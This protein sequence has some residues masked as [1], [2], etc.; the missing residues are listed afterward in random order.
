M[1]GSSVQ[2]NLVN[3]HL[4]EHNC[5]GDHHVFVANGTLDLAYDWWE[6]TRFSVDAKIVNGDV[7]AFIPGDA[8]FHLS[9][10]TDSGGIENDF[11]NQK[12]RSGGQVQRIDTM[13]GAPSGAAIKI[14]TTNG[15]IKIA[16]VNP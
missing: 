8:A 4:S 13:V 10:A 9:A 1:R 2:A 7:H 12:D 6:K 11:S 15:S 14:Q 3:G 5:F 16:E